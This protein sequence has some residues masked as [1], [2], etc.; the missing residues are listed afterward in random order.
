MM[1]RLV[2]VVALVSSGCAWHA[3]LPWSSDDGSV[4]VEVSRADPQVYERDLEPLLQRELSRAVSDWIGAALVSPGE[5]D[6]LVR[7]RIVEYRR[8]GGIRSRDHVLLESG[9]KLAVEAEL[10]ERASGRVLQASAST[11]SGYVLD[12]PDNE[13]AALDRALA[14]VAETL[15]LELFR[16]S[17]P[18]RDASEL[19]D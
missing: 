15:V 16:E 7:T 11:W 4:G 18:S 17:P 13:R 10:V 6:W 8:R 12:D 9:I 2:L 19:P 3:G 1:R 14:H 5:A